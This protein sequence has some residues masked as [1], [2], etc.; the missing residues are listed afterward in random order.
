MRKLPGLWLALALALA[1]ACARERSQPIAPEPSGAAER[2][3]VAAASGD[4][5]AGR[6]LVRFRPGAPTASVLSAQQVT[7]Q[8][9]L[10]L[11]IQMLNVP[12]GRERA[13][14][15][16]LARNPWVEFV[17]PDYIRTIGIPCES[18]ECNAPTDT[19]FGYRWDL[20]NDGTVT[21][22]LGQNLAN[23]GK[24]DADIDWLEA[25]DQLGDFTGSARIGIT[26]TGIK[27]NHEDLAGRIAAQ[28]DFFN[29]DG[30]ANDDDGHGTHVAGISGGSGNNGRGIP[31]VAWGP[32]IEFVVAKVCG[33]IPGF[34][35]G[36]PS[37]DIA[38]GIR[39]AA[40]NGAN[41]INISLGGPVGSQTE[42]QALQYAR[43]LDVLVFCAAGNES[44]PVSYPAA[45]PECVG[46]SATDWGDNLASY[47]NFGTEVEIA[48]PGG[49]FENGGYSMILSSYRR[50][51]PP[52]AFLAGT[53][54]A[55]PQV[56]GL[57]ALLH[58]LG[59]TDDEEKLDRIKATADDLGA[60]GVDPLFGAG[61][62]NVFDAINYGGPPPPPPPPPAQIELTATKIGR[63]SRW[64][65][66]LQWSGAIG[67]QVEVYRD[68][69]L[70]TTTSNDGT[71]RDPIGS[72]SGTYTYKVCELGGLVCSNEAPV[73]I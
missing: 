37:S 69:A 25:F 7:I 70:L 27:S 58:A 68:G 66:Q 21:N 47:S 31:G 11:G 72:T 17:E 18:G 12:V 73:T 30:N 10:F 40:D 52:Y 33:F 67:S 22:S 2:G 6:L 50:G 63:D 57:A 36:C 53:S 65:A 24:V 51:R 48:A 5:V 46:V 23:T 1:T 8:R 71:H 20:H 35:V 54:M 32:N 56:T 9:E 45:F 16:A 26:D 62:I 4:Y 39:F 14:A 19:Y 64:G 28:F 42:Q 44:G 34:G 38:D 59:V 15:D 3:L 49:D 61:R 60:P 43:N 29:N 41:A 13:I 55:T